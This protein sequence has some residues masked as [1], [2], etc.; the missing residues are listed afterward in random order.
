MLMEYRPAPR[1]VVAG[2]NIEP[3]SNQFFS[4]ICSTINRKII[5]SSGQN[6]H[7]HLTNSVE[8][9]TTREAT[10]CAAIR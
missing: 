1:A 2:R 10:S 8:L 9:S 5:I 4:T 3:G 6:Y 7:K